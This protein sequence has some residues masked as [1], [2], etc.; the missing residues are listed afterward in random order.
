MATICFETK[1]QSR[2][3]VSLYSLLA[4]IES[5]FETTLLYKSTCTCTFGIFPSVANVTNIANVANV[6]NV[7][8]VASVVIVASVTS[9]DIVGNV[10][11]VQVF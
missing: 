1:L 8:N 4:P 9:D 6:V 2:S 10:D 11:N 5:T 7:A 3:V